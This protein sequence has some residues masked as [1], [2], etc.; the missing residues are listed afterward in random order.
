LLS[1]HHLDVYLHNVRG[2][3]INIAVVLAR[4]HIRVSGRIRSAE[5]CLFTS[6][7]LTLFTLE[8]L[9]HL[10]S[11]WVYPSRDL[12]TAYFIWFIKTHS[13]SEWE[14]ESERER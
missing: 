2:D 6:Q 14:R 1:E 11:L 12:C 8:S 9:L 13:V 7:D 10:Y 3:W 4:W 5:I